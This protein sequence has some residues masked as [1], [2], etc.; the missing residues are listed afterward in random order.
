MLERGTTSSAL[1]SVTRKRFQRQRIFIM[2]T[3]AG[4]LLLFFLGSGIPIAGTCATHDTHSVGSVSSC[5]VFQGGNLCCILIP[6]RSRRPRHVVC[7]LRPRKK[8]KTKKS[9]QLS[10]SIGNLLALAVL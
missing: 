2:A 1:A 8:R 10:C 6:R 7:I 9:E 3:N 5:S 4:V